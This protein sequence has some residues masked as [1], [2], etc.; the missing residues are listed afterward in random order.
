METNNLNEAEFEGLI[1]KSKKLILN[2]RGKLSWTGD[3]EKMRLDEPKEI[4]GE[5]END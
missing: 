5:E 1:R 3:L 4:N 2:L